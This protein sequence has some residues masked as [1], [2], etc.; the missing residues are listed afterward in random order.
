MDWVFGIK[1]SKNCPFSVV[2]VRKDY[3]EYADSF[4]TVSSY[5]SE[6]KM[7][8]SPHLS[9]LSCGQMIDVFNV[10]LARAKRIP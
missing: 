6:Q 5:L 8:E 2:H 9:V 7:K 3:P 1:P 10:D 4:W